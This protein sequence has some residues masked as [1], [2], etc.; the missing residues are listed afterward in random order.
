M[1]RWMTTGPCVSSCG[2]GV[3]DAV[4]VVHRCAHGL[5]LL[6]NREQKKQECAVRTTAAAVVV[7]VVRSRSVSLKVLKETYY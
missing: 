2:C 5:T 6:K 1:H 7:S 3:R 4:A